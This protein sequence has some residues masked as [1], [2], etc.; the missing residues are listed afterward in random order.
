MVIGAGAAGL[1]AAAMLRRRGI[2]PLVITHDR[3]PGAAWRRRYEGLRLNTVRWMSDLPGYRMDRRYGRWPTA[4]DWADYLERYAAHHDL[5]I[6]HDVE[7]QRID[8]R[9]PGWALAT[10]NAEIRA[11]LVV[12][13]TGLDK[14]P[15]IPDWPGRD[16]F[17]GELIHSADFRDAA[18]FEGKRALVAG[19]GNSALEIATLLRRSGAREV[20]VAIRRPPTILRR[21]YFG[22]PLTLLSWL[23]R[24]LPDRLLDVAG[25][26]VPRLTFGDLS[27]HGLGRPGRR[28][29]DMR[30]Q[31]YVPPIDSGFVDHVKAGDIEVVPAVERFDGDAVVH[32]GERR[33]AADAVIAATG[34]STG[35]RPL[36]GHLGVLRESDDIPLV[37]GARTLPHAPGLHFIGYHLVL[38]AV[39]PHLETEARRLARGIAGQ[40][41][42]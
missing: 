29:S 13:A 18:T 25:W 39:L 40:A 9:P 33:T 35:L 32:T 1:A 36:V 17:T 19:S 27:A 28:L 23:A 16:G 31:N 21:Q 12:V 11:A 24:G 8:A 7:V 15:K 2:E 37:H 42:R 38:T 26:T 4:D 34:Y 6:E 3:R 22:I 5:R 14:D 41:R 10:A 20:R 30:R